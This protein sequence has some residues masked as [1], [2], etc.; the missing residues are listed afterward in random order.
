MHTEYVEKALD[1]DTGEGNAA[2]EE[3]HTIIDSLL[4]KAPSRSV[5]SGKETF[6]IEDGTPYASELVGV[7][8]SFDQIRSISVSGSDGKADTKRGV[9][10]L[11][12]EQQLMSY[13]R[14][15][16]LMHCAK[17]EAAFDTLPE[18]LPSNIRLIDWGCGQGI[19]SM[20][21]IERY[22]SEQVKDILL[23]EPSE[24]AL[25]RAALHL[26]KYD[27]DLAIR[28]VCA[29]LDELESSIFTIEKDDCVIHLFSNILD[30]EEYSQ[31]RLIELIE[32]TH[33]G[34]NY[35][36]CVSPHIT[37]IEEER[38]NSFKRHFQQRY[39]DSF[40]LLSENTDTKYSPFWLCNENKDCEEV[41][42]GRG[43]YCRTDYT[44]IGGCRK[45]W[46][47]VERVFSVRWFSV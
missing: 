18:D 1:I 27:E 16:G 42:H 5:Y 40:Q 2:Y 12:T 10:I 3:I 23:I 13:M 34:N 44:P 15:L 46:T 20:L 28:T 37:G 43:F 30:I 31:E 17:L 24:V 36:I 8:A 25:G 35:F 14:N 4:C 11:E 9:G 26:K 39:S 21:F 45:K 7:E 29:K 32:E 19:A 6:I 47:R 41:T 22:G 33:T 38:L